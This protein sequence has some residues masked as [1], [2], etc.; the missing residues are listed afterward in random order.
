MD[1]CFL[2]ISV[3]IN[4]TRWLDYLLILGNSLQFS[5]WHT[6]MTRAGL[7]VCP[8]LNKSSHKR[9]RPLKYCQNGES[10]PNL[11]TLVCMH[12]PKGKFIS[13]SSLYSLS[14]FHMG[15]IN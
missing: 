11:V 1:P 5:Q 4:V 10:S 12:I 7:N 14:H 2:Y 6:I 15:M 9:L 3:W 8:T 13:Q